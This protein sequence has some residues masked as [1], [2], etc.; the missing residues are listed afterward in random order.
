MRV[1][2]DN[3]NLSQVIMIFLGFVQIIATLISG[4]LMD[5]FPKK[6]FLIGGQLTMMTCLFLIFQFDN[7]E[8]AIIVLVFMHTIAYSF[9]VGQLLMYY[10]AKLLENTGKVILVNWL[11]TFFVALSA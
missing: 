1:T 4:K 10:A 6:I 9:S 7:S 8:L 3:N 5:K 11:F 2:N